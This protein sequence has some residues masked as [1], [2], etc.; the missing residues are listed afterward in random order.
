MRIGLFDVPEL[1]VM[2]KR[3]ARQSLFDDL[4]DLGKARAALV[5]VDVV[6]VV[7]HPRGATP[8]AE[9]QGALRQAVEHGDFFGQPQR[10]IPGQHQHRGA[11]RQIRKFRGD[12]RHHQQRA[13]RR[14]VVAEMMLE[15][16]GRVIAE[17]VAQRAI[18]H[19][20]RIELL[21]GHAGHIG[22]RRLKS[23]P[24]ILHCHGLRFAPILE[25]PGCVRQSIVSS[26]E[27][28]LPNICSFC[29]ASGSQPKPYSAR[30]TRHPPPSVGS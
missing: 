3:L 30:R 28:F 21:V 5:H 10:M 22:R 1:A 23:E 27:I 20:V 26:D 29:R 14:V 18:R 15:Q 8:D 19:Q 24:H 13:R 7:F 25:R 4:E 16:P 2:R 17:P 11:E 12:M 9:M 6:G